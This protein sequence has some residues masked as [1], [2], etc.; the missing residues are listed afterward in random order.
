MGVEAADF[1]CW[2]LRPTE[3]E[4]GDCLE[5][6][7]ES[8]DSCRTESG[9]QGCPGRCAGGSD[10]IADVQGTSQLNGA[11]GHRVRQ[12]P[13]CELCRVRRRR[14]GA[15]NDQPK[16]DRPEVGSHLSR[17]FPVISPIKERD[18]GG[19]RRV[20]LVLRHYEKIKEV[21]Y[22]SN[23]EVEGLRYCRNIVPSTY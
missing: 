23:Y 14:S 15:A 8:G 22:W 21:S 1:S 12:S 18:I 17:P 3:V 13:L 4:L 11:I 19:D 6:P 9:G 5:V 2:V 10:K 7:E 16:A 20:G